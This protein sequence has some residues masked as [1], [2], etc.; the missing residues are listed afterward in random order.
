MAIEGYHYR[1][2]GLDN[3]YLL[4][5]YVVEK[6]PYGEVVTIH[7][8]DGLHRAIGTYLVR[9]RKDLTGTEVRFL[10]HELGMSQK[11]LGDVLGKT[12]QTVARWEKE[13]KEINGT[14][15][16]LL[17]VLYQQHVGGNRK[18]RSLLE[19]LADLDDLVEE[20]IRFE[21]PGDGWRHH[22]A[23]AA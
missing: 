6:S 21:D 22:I 18:V 8:I 15:T 1:E 4:N 19:Q 20:Q 10:R 13:P 2:C 16:R 17:R 14:A 9:E 7:D 3:I 23:E 5:G 12:E 11:V